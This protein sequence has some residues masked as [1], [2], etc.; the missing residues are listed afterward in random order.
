MVD[1]AKTFQHLYVGDD[2]DKLSYKAVEKL[3][4]TMHLYFK[5]QVLNVTSITQ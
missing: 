4:T 2:S 5:V 3:M 1:G